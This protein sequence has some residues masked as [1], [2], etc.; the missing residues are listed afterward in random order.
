MIDSR[1][2]FITNTNLL[3]GIM[4][5][6]EQY[7]NL[8]Y[9]EVM[10]IFSDGTMFL[11]SSQPNWVL[12]FINEKIYHYDLTYFSPTKEKKKELVMFHNQQI[13]IWQ[14]KCDYLDLGFQIIFTE[15]VDDGCFFFYCGTLT[16]KYKFG[17]I[18][19][20]NLELLEKFIMNFPTNGK[21]LIDSLTAAKI[22]IDGFGSESEFAVNSNVSDKIN[23]L[24]E[25]YNCSF[26]PR[27][28]DYIRLLAKGNTAKEITVKL[29]LSYRTVEEYIKRLKNKTGANSIY[30]LITQIE[31][32]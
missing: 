14:F 26:T 19:I 20:T 6:L 23:S 3:R 25:I 21:L 10:K 31:Q 32:V 2:P 9:F 17:N 11:C 18:P 15:P 16:K 8:D 24:S 4:S 13:P 5:P 22:V 28:I 7:L 27:E 29:G 12:K 30:E 1:H